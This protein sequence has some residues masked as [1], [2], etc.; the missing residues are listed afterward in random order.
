MILVAR[1]RVEL[2]AED[3]ESTVLPLHHRAIFPHS[4]LHTHYRKKPRM[5]KQLLYMLFNILYTQKKQYLNQFKHFLF[6]FCWHD[7]LFYDIILLNLFF[8]PLQNVQL[9]ISRFR[10]WQFCV[11]RRPRLRSLYTWG[12]YWAI[13]F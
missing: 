6:Y 3:Y 9:V 1:S 12:S 7:I 10:F 2:E 8:N 5:K 13:I 4:W 11:T